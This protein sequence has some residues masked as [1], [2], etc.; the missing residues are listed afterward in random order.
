MNG[1]YLMKPR[2]QIPALVT[3]C[4]GSTLKGKAIVIPFYIEKAVFFSTIFLINSDS[5]LCRKGSGF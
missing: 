4:Q 2:C 3:Q 5:I 1:T